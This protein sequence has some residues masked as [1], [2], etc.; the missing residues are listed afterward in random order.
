MPRPG[1]GGLSGLSRP[2]H[3][4]H[5][6]T[7]L[8]AVRLPSARRDPAG[9]GG[10]RPGRRATAVGELGSG[11]LASPLARAGL[12]RPPETRPR[13]QGAS[14][15]P[16][17]PLASSIEVGTPTRGRAPGS[18]VVWALRP[19][20][21]GALSPRGR[22]PSPRAGRPVTLGRVPGARGWAPSPRGLFLA[23]AAARVPG[24]V[25]LP[26][27]PGADS[28]LLSLSPLQE[29]CDHSAAAS[30]IARE[31]SSKQTSHLN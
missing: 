20:G 30:N 22:R 8:A 31:A 24:R 17:L 21:L 18:C 4:C 15:R 11:G 1:G 13:G 29:S 19:A 28:R 9:P 3:G 14:G 2:Q 7:A 6:P 26:Q 23:P 27:V 25:F 16:R 12:A 10:K 5:C